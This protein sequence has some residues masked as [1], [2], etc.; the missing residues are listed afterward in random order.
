MKLFLVFGVIALLIPA[1][2]AVI[3]KIR[4]DEYYS[5]ERNKDM[6]RIFMALTLCLL[7]LVT[8][9]GTAQSPENTDPFEQKKMENFISKLKN[10]DE[11]ADFNTYTV[12][13]EK[14][15]VDVN[16]AFS[17][18]GLTAGDEYNTTLPKRF[19]YEWNMPGYGGTFCGPGVF[20]GNELTKWHDDDCIYVFLY[21]KNSTGDPDIQA[22]TGA[23]YSEGVLKIYVDADMKKAGEVVTHTMTNI[24]LAVEIEKSAVEG[25]ES[26]EFVFN[27]TT[28]YNDGK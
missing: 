16:R 5:K 13:N 17:G 8:A 15:N 22:I 23:D 27:D 24:H 7:M 6:K 19:G 3:H 2:V 28:P 18:G 9:C 10:P 26:V 1:T 4:S 20:D 25:L 21:G 12:T 14:G 11:V